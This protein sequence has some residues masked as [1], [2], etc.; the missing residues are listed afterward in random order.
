MNTK[1]Y[2]CGCAAGPAEEVP[3]YCPEHGV[4]HMTPE[5]QACFAEACINPPETAEALKTA[6]LRRKALIQDLVA[7][8]MADLAAGRVVSQEYAKK[9]YEK[10]VNPTLR[11]LGVRLGD[12]LNDDQWHTIEPL[13]NDG[14]YTL[15]AQTSYLGP[16]GRH[17][18]L[19]TATR[20][21][22]GSSPA[23]HRLQHLT[24]T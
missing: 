5:D 13:L 19:A 18:R 8:G 16:G 15:D 6:F 10:R 3:N 24:V 1:T 12:L 22:G 17:G 23:D 11:D 4:I 7:A 21:P 20:D 14:D 2:P 9:L